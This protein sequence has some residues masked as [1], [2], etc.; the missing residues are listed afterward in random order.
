MLLDSR[1]MVAASKLWG[2]VQCMSSIDSNTEDRVCCG[3][4]RQMARQYATCGL[5]RCGEDEILCRQ[6]KA[7]CAVQWTA[8]LHWGMCSTAD[9]QHGTCAACKRPQWCDDVDGDS[10]RWPHGT[11]RSGSEWMAAF[12]GKAHIQAHQ[13]KWKPDQVDQLIGS[14]RAFL[15]QLQAA[16]PAV[17]SR[18][19]SRGNVRAINNEVNLYVDPPMRALLTDALVGRV[20]LTP[21]AGSTAAGSKQP[22]SAVNNLQLLRTLGSK[23]RALGKDVPLLTMDYE[24]PLPARGAARYARMAWH[25]GTATNLESRLELIVEQGSRSM[26]PRVTRVPSKGPAAVWTPSSPGSPLR[27]IYW[28]HIPKTGSEFSYTIYAYACGPSSFHPQALRDGWPARVHGTCGGNRSSLQGDLKPPLGA[29]LEQYW[30][31]SPVPWSLPNVGNVVTMFRR[32]NQRMLSAIQMLSTK[33]GNCCGPNWGWRP[34]ERAL[35]VKHATTC[36]RVQRGELDVISSA[37]FKALIQSPSFL[38][39]QAKMLLGHGCFAARQLSKGDIFLAVKYARTRVQFIGLTESW[40]QSVC[41]WHARFGGPLWSSELHS[42][43]SLRSSST[44]NSSSHN[45]S[46]LLKVGFDSDPADELVYSIAQLRFAVE[47][48]GHAEAVAEC[49]RMVDAFKAAQGTSL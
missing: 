9:I 40:Q 12:S 16:E 8:P 17:A 3:D 25:P 31:H 37:S 41:L 33:A 38:G 49:M 28:L 32:P 4:H 2:A 42:R 5:R 7:G 43:K 26:S 15:H 27:Q 29:S 21:R 23:L 10:T 11:I 14:A 22:A 30:F 46:I 48:S 24:D 18:T 34:R 45:E 13:C 39:C 19:L 36:C 47:V 44:L 35:A 6:I 20:L 1:A